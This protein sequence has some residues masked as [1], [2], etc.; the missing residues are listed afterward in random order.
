MAGRA[1]EAH[2]RSSSARTLLAHC[3]QAQPSAANAELG[4]LGGGRAKDDTTCGQLLTGKRY[5]LWWHTPCA[6]TALQHWCALQL[7]ATGTTFPKTAHLLQG[8][9]FLWAGA[10]RGQ[11]VHKGTSQ[12]CPEDCNADKR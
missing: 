6:D 7:N 11:A 4:S 8:V 5:V 1:I 10:E 3:S 12:I 2:A 9:G